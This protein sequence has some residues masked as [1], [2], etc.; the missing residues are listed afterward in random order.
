[1]N[2][3][4]Q[5]QVSDTRSA[6]VENSATTDEECEYA[7]TVYLFF[8]TRKNHDDTYHVNEVF[9]CYNLNAPNVSA[10]LLFSQQNY[11]LGAD[12]GQIQKLGKGGFLIAAKQL[13]WPWGVGRK[14][15]HGACLKAIPDCESISKFAG[16]LAHFSNYACTET[17]SRHGSRCLLQVN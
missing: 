15:P 3:L 5:Y 12:E 11:W 4:P 16:I 7:H 1:M 14:V 17:L 9:H 10:D 2:I 8:G 13:K 6:P